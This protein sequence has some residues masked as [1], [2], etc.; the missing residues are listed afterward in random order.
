[1]GI[2]ITSRVSSETDC[3]SVTSERVRGCGWD[4]CF[5][6]VLHHTQEKS[7]NLC[8]QVLCALTSAELRRQKLTGQLV[9]GVLLPVLE[10]EL[11]TSTGSV[12]A[13]FQ[14]QELKESGKNLLSPVLL[15]FL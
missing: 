4:G 1:M 6:C 2:Y 15:P 12:W 3:T 11:G 9:P 13:L 5:C 14:S 8:S 10:K 7:S